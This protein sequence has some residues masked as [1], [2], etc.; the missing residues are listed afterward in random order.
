[1]TENILNYRCLSRKLTGSSNTI[2]ANY[3]PKQ[4]REKVYKL[5]E[6]IED[7]LKADK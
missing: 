2:R 1:M 6:I 7:Y 3:V 4:F 5:E